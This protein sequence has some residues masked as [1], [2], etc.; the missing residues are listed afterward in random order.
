MASV[1]TSS[2][3]GAGTRLAV[4]YQTRNRVPVHPRGIGYLGSLRQKR[5]F[6]VTVALAPYRAK[7][8][9]L[10]RVEAMFI[11]LQSADLGIQG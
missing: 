6:R 7:P 4:W 8:H 9:R 11:D 2:Q 5:G 1:S 3:F 10:I